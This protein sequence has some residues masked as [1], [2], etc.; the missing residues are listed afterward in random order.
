MNAAAQ[1]F[2]I[3]RTSSLGDV[4]HALPALRTLRANHPKA[5]IAWLIEERYR[6]LLK[7][8]PDLDAVIAVRTKA[9]R[10]KF[11]LKTLREI[12]AALREIRGAQFDVVFDLQGLIKSGVISWLSGAKRRIGFHKSDCKEAANTWFNNEQAAAISKETHVV[13]RYQQLILMA[14]GDKPDAA[15]PVFAVPPEDQKRIEAFYEANTEFS[16]RP[17][18]AINPGA[19]FPSKLWQPERFAVLADRMVNELGVSIL[20]TWGPG[21]KDKVERIAEKMQAPCRLAPE[22]SILESIALYRQL[23]LMVSCDS[24]PL[25]LCAALGI[26][27]VA[28]FGP[29]DP[30]R[31]GPY[32]NPHATVVKRL[33]CSF[34]W[35]KTCPL[36]THECME[37]ISVDDVFQA[38]ERITTQ[39]NK[40]IPS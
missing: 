31:N 29:T 16:R 8:N 36:E 5:H 4:V 26:P 37:S 23:S 22:T 34:C 11:N 27:T 1:K 14:G 28:L 12:R 20:F 39:C 38:V 35:K 40:P 17:I 13:E 30:A 32:G 10:K 25:H 9:W 21:E 3:I 18:A 6:D 2:L 24:G 33:S 15:L 7:D 19:G